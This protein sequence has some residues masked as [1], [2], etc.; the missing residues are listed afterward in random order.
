MIPSIDCR[1]MDHRGLHNACRGRGFF[2]LT[3][4]GIDP[5]LIEASLAATDQFFA[6]PLNI[7]NRT[8]RRAANCMAQF[9]SERLGVSER[10]V[11]KWSQTRGKHLIYQ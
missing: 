6:Q 5:A 9:V 7:K 1:H 2:V 11:P 4:H 10:L 8:R 3:G